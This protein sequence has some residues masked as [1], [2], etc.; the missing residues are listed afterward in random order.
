MTK[1]KK[2]GYEVGFCNP[3]KQHQFSKGK[4]GN[5]RGRPSKPARSLTTRQSIVDVLRIA[6]K[7]IN[8]RRGAKVV[9]VP[10]IE[11]IWESVAAKA[12]NGHAPSQRLMIKEHSHALRQLRNRHSEFLNAIERW[13]DEAAVATTGEHP[14]PDQLALN[15]FKRKT[16]CL[17]GLPTARRDPYLKELARE[18]SSF[19]QLTRERDEKGIR[20]AS[21]FVIDAG[22][23]I[24]ETGDGRQLLIAPHNKAALGTALGVR[25][26][27][28]L[29]EL[30]G[31][32][33]IV[34]YS[35]DA[36]DAFLREKK[37]PFEESRR[38][39][40]SQPSTIGDDAND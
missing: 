13:E 24:E 31:G 18:W 15:Y 10:I 38:A 2:P 37:I 34:L 33:A 9:S 12:A 39:P 35:Y 20:K 19:E 40:L 30:K 7:Q 22:I 5:P 26:N 32:L 17:A 23:L 3:P 28:S 6:E 11:A 27:P 1:D 16:S 21:F 36:V 25:G 14:Y 4:S 8:M 29:E